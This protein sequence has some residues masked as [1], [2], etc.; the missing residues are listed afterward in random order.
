[1]TKVYYHH[2]DLPKTLLDISMEILAKVGI[3]TLS[4]REVARQADVSHSA[5]YRHFSNK[6]ELLNEISKRGFN[7]LVSLIIQNTRPFRGAPRTI[8]LA[9]ARSYLQ[10][11]LE[12]KNLYELMFTTPT[13]SQAM[14]FTNS[15]NIFFEELRTMLQDAQNKGVLRKNTPDIQT[16]MFWSMLHGLAD[17]LIKPEFTTA[18]LAEHRIEDI[19]RNAVENFLKATE[20]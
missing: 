3:D 17:L 1:M 19:V 6:Y 16:I 18:V 9:T 7:D 14:S 4:L 10:F 5:V 2:G 12:N 8:I 11:A 15:S 13:N 20:A